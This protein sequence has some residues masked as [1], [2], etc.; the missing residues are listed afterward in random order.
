MLRV[1]ALLDKPEIKAL[2][3]GGE[4]W[5]EIDDI[6]DLDIAASIFTPD[7]EEH[8]RLME[9][10]YG[11][12]WRYPRIRDFC[13]L[14]N[15]YFPNKRLMSELKANFER[16]VREYPS[17]MRVNSL[18]AAKYFGISQEYICIGNGAA[19]LIK[20]LMSRL[21]GKMGVIYPTFEE[22]PNRVKPDMVVPFH[23]ASRN[24]TYTADDLMEFFSG[25]DIGTLLLVNPGNPSGFFLPKGDVLRLCL[26]T[27]TRGIRLI[28][29]ESFV[30][31]SCGMPDNTLLKD[32]ILEEYP[33]LAVVK[34]ISK[35][36]GVPGL[37][38]GVLASAD[39]ELAAWIKKD[40]SIW[41]I[42]SIAE[43]YMQIFGKYEQSYVRACNRFMKE[44]DR[45]MQ[46][47]SRVPFLNVFPSQANYFMCEVKPPMKARSLTGLLLK[48]HSILV[49]DCSRKKGFEG[50]EF[51]RIAV[52][53]ATD[54]DALVR[55][56]HA[57]IGPEPSSICPSNGFPSLSSCS[58]SAS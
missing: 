3:L 43:F 54:N 44:R 21:E 56:M 22:Y 40:V 46:E 25:K 23:T 33:H 47:L 1:I 15:P 24:F 53:D 48:N 20:A 34:S 5:Y 58:T 4:A 32:G 37:R 36:Y 50:R 29:D 31:F 41:N 30:D 13:Y 17:G 18:L 57:E 49:K 28:V 55:A 45:F 8:L 12:Y 38:L 16:L 14:V 9:S 19:E 39:R 42:N 7:R 26:W 52:R 11:G 35:S 10:R 6:Q 2:R 51:I 27:K